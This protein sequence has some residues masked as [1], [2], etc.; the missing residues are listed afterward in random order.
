MGLNLNIAGNL[1]LSIFTLIS[2]NIHV[3]H[4]MLPDNDHIGTIANSN[5]N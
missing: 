3:W 4:I 2:V 5:N 1:E